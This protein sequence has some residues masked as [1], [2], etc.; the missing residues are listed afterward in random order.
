MWTKRKLLK[1]EE[2][3]GI[4]TLIGPFSLSRNKFKWNCKTKYSC[5]SIF[6]QEVPRIN[7]TQF[8]HEFK[9][10]FGNYAKYIYMAYSFPFPKMHWKYFQNTTPR[11]WWASTCYK[12][13][14]YALII[15]FGNEKLPQ[16]FEIQIVTI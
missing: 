8:W 5:A 11:L 3:K 1:R 16:W 15:N 12:L 14:I 6:V 4:K 2:R 7:F 13:P 9:P 10:Y